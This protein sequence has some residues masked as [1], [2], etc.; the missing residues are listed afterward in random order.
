MQIDIHVSTLNRFTEENFATL[1]ALIF[2][3]KAFEKVYHISEEFPIHPS[4][5]CFCKPKNKTEMEMYGMVEDFEPGNSTK[6][7]S[8][9][10]EVTLKI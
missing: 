4:H 6:P 2:V 8:Y 3:K 5:E 1:I 9:P 7:H 10:C